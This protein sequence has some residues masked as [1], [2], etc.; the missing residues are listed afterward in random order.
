MTESDDPTSLL[1][2]GLNRTPAGKMAGG[3][4]F[5]DDDKKKDRKAERE[6]DRKDRR[7]RR[8]DASSLT[9]QQPPTGIIS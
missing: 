9:G 8:R 7:K 5:G 4:L 3:I 1:K 2:R 6:S